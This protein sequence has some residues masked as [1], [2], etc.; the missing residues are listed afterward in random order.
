[1]MGVNV[2]H[3]NVWHANAKR[4]FVTLAALVISSYLTISP[5]FADQEILLKDGSRILG[6]IISMQGGEYRVD[7][8]SMGVLTLTA[9]QIQ[10]ISS[11]GAISSE[12]AVN[13]A[14][15]ISNSADASAKKSAIQSMRSTMT[16]S[17]S[18]MSAILSLQNDPEMQAILQ[19]PEVM[20]A[21]QN[22]DLTALANNPKIKKLMNNSK[23]KN[24]QGSVN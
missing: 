2:W 11:P 5:A 21:V 22:F 7:T 17:P 9:K 4:F 12:S 23:I 18:V 6:K 24:I 10:R 20:Q 1:M 8:K 16:S 15:S 19:D 14:Q 13:S 3:A